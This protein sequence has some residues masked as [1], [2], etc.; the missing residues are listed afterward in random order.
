MYNKDIHKKG[1]GVEICLTYVSAILMTRLLYQILSLSN[2]DTI[3]NMYACAALLFAAARAVLCYHIHDW[4]L[5][6]C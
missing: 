2:A 6:V 4:L 1:T 3:L 5:M